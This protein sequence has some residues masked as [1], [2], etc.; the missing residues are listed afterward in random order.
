MS[1]GYVHRLDKLG[2]LMNE[3]PNEVIKILINN[4]TTSFAL[5]PKGGQKVAKNGPES[6]QK[7]A[8]NGPESG[9]KV[10]KPTPIP[11]RRRAS[12]PSVKNKNNNNTNSLSKNPTLKAGEISD[13]DAGEPKAE[14]ETPPRQTHKFYLGVLVTFCQEHPEY[15]GEAVGK[16][17]SQF[18]AHRQSLDT[19]KKFGT[20]TA[21]LGV[22]RKLHKLSSKMKDPAARAA[23]LLRV[24]TEMRWMTVFEPKEEPSAADT[25]EER[26]Q[27]TLA[28]NFSG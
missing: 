25:A 15:E 28:R 22:L 11:S 10:A 6:G 16:A 24:A 13:K 20:E 12:S 1:D 19:R 3:E 14:K 27:E 23:E 26:W 7:V 17:W 9:Q 4:A 5:W 8:K 18:V 2:E 21:A